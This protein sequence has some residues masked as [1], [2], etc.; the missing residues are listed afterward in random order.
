MKILLDTNIIMDA[1]Q[2]RRPFD[3]E[4]REI[5]LRAQ[6]SQISAVFTATA[7]AASLAVGL[8][9]ISLL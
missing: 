7:N 1:L 6:S 5:L 3:Y 4:A 8:L 9:L 2:E